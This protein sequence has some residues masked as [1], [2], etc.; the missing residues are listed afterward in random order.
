MG[1]RSA[2]RP[3]PVGN[4]V[5]ATFADAGHIHNHMI[6]RTG[7]RHSHRIGWLP[8]SLGGVGGRARDD[9]VTARSTCEGNRCG[10]TSAIST[11]TAASSATVSSAGASPASS[12]IAG[13]IPCAIS[14]SSASAERASRSRRQ[15][16]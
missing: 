4:M 7:D 16:P 5:I 11:G 6:G 1:Q 8:V 12:R 14:R 15:A 9:H 13:N 2:Q 10:G 3:D